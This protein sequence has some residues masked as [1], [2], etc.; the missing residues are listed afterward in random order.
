MPDFWVGVFVCMGLTIIV[1]L[2]AIKRAIKDA[3]K[4]MKNAK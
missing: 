2:F 3:K 1:V 4:G